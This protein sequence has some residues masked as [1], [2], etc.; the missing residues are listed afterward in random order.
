MIRW[1][2]LVRYPD[3]VSVEEGD[4]WYLGTHVHEARQMPGLRRYRTW[5]LRP[6][7]SPGAGRPLEALNRW[8]RMTELA[9]DD[10]DAWSH[11]VNGAPVDFTP[12]PWAQKQEGT[13]SASYVSE[14]IFIDD[15]PQYD[16]LRD[17]PPT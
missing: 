17:P 10:W 2:F 8:T 3:G 1:M 13:A 12:A 6:A 7:P 5:A 9:F 15:E 11:A 14:T 16:L 4:A